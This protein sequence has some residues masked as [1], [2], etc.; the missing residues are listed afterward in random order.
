MKLGPDFMVLAHR[1]SDIDPDSRDAQEI[2]STKPDREPMIIEPDEERRAI[3][4]NL[5]TLPLAILGQKFVS[6]R[7]GQQE[8]PGSDSRQNE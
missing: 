7:H 3:V 4:L 8:N 1:L 2:R 5:V 6:M